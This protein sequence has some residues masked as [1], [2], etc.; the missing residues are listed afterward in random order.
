MIM[1]GLCHVCFHSNKE[2]FFS[3]KDGMTVCAN[4][5]ADE[6]YNQSKEDKK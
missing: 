4:C 1:K 3:K 5:A 6:H 2:I